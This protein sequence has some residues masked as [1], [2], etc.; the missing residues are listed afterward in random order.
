MLRDVPGSCRRTLAMGSAT[1]E[2]AS[3]TRYF[4]RGFSSPSKQCVGLFTLSF[5][6]LE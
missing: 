2:H 4:D 5:G 6:Y 3:G 1:F